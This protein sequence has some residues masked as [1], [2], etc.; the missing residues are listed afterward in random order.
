[1][2]DSV[3]LDIEKLPDSL[4]KDKIQDFLMQLFNRTF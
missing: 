3:F 4:E 2:N 1:M